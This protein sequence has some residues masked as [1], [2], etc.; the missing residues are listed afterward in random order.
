MM[1]MCKMYALLTL[2]ELLLLYFEP[3]FL[4]LYRDEDQ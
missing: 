1:N 3:R 4:L 2:H